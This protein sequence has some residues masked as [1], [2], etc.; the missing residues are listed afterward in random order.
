MMSNKAGRR[1]LP[2]AGE[3]FVKMI[4]VARSVRAKAA[5]SGGPARTLATMQA[6]RDELA[7]ARCETA[8]G[9]TPRRVTAVI[10][11]DE[12][13]QRRGDRRQQSHPPPSRVIVAEMIPRVIG[14]QIGPGGEVACNSN[15]S[16]N[17]TLPCTAG[18]A[19]RA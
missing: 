6:L 11:R 3:M 18:A 19:V 5:A 2:T 13:D 9:V 10:V 12:R 1:S 4:V 16:L 7:I 15:I 17:S 14:G 8:A